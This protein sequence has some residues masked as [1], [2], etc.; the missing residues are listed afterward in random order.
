LPNGN[1]FSIALKPYEIQVYAFE[2]E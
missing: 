1:N 2:I